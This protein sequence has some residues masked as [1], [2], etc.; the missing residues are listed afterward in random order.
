M[1]AR[2]LR[3]L[4]ASPTPHGARHMRGILA[5]FEDFSIIGVA[6]DISTLYECAEARDP[7]LIVLSEKLT[8]APEFEVLRSLFVSLDIRWLVLAPRSLTS[9]PARPATTRKSDLFEMDSA[10]SPN[11]LAKQIRSVCCTKRQKTPTPRPTSQSSGIQGL[12][13][14]LV[15]IGA[16]T[17]GVDAL[18][19][20][21]S[22][23]NETCPPTMIVQHTGHRFLSSLTRLLQRNC[24]ANVIA[25]RD[26]LTLKPGMVV[27]ASEPDHHLRLA[28]Q[29]PFTCR[30]T[31][32]SERGGHVPS[33]DTLFTSAVPHAEKILAVILS[34]MGRDG[35]EG[36]LALRRGGATTL[37]QDKSTSVVFGMPRVAHEIGA[38]QHLMPLQKIGP[39]IVSPHRPTIRP[40][41]P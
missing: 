6:H 40:D 7:D 31:R 9:D 26:G 20:I 11:R 4:I 17:G 13:G 14:N 36:M 34:G 30:I 33:V 22:H 23:F 21:L 8:H 28:K 5:Q 12:K 35:A 2:P 24:A 27:V 1:T 39:Y 32:A 18:I 38:A 16:S 29:H 25:A 3:I 37:A 15:L 10:I 19:E 41:H